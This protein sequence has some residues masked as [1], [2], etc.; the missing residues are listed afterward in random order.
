MK[1]GL[2]GPRSALYRDLGAETGE[3]RAAVRGRAKR[4]RLACST[5]NS[6]SSGSITTTFRR[7]S[8]TE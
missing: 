1:L 2:R 6:Y 8:P 5:W 7:P 3:L 4:C